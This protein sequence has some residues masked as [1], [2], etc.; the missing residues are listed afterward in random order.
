[1]LVNAHPALWP[2]LFELTLGASI[3]WPG[4]LRMLER[5]A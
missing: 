5:A 1:V 2:A 4:V 3:D